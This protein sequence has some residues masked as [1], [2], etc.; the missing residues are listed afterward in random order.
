MRSI[1]FLIFTVISIPAVLRQPLLGVAIY[2]G[3]NIIRPEMFFWGGETGSYVFKFFF[4]FAF[5]SCLYNGYLKRLRQVIQH[6]YLLML[7]LLLALAIS[8]LVGQYEVERQNYFLLEFCKGIFFIVLIYISVENFSDLYRIQLVLV[9]CLTFL[10]IWGVQQSFLGNE[11][12]EG[13]GGHSWGDSNGMAATFVLFLPVTLSM[14]IITKQR[15]RSCLFLSMV[16]LFV[17]F[18]ILTKSRAGLLGMTASIFAFGYYS[19]KLTKIFIIA[20]IISLASMPFLSDSYIE[21]MKTITK[22]SDSDKLEGSARSR[23]ILWEAGLMIF[24]NN[25]LFGTGF[26]TYP[27]AKMKYKNKFSH[28]QEDFQD[29]VFRTENKKVTHN[30]YIQLLSDCG[31]FGAVPFFLLVIGSIGKGFIA[32]RLLKDKIEYLKNDLII[33]SGI[34]AGITGFAVCII[35]MDAVLILLLY[36]QIVL[37]SMLNRMVLNKNETACVV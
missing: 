22:V 11:R 15:W 37:A 20:A 32:R 26:L 19:R 10:A 4:I 28:L 23:L 6:E 1:I 8:V 2:L 16:A 21:R 14:F 29:W 33:L 30:T 36:V 7:W 25:P 3:A 12:L 35:T 18:I 27:E 34:S 5:A 31:L 17:I 13:L 9:G 24:A